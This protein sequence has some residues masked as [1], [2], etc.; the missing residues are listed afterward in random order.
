LDN[1]TTRVALAGK[2]NLNVCVVSLAN[3]NMTDSVLTQ[4]FRDAPESCI[5]LIEDIDA[6]FP[7]RED[8]HNLVRSI[9]CHSLSLITNQNPVRHPQQGAPPELMMMMRANNRPTSSVTFSGILNAIDGIASQ[10]GFVLFNDS[11]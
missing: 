2:L 8:H 10:E 3:I 6:A 11:R 1:L 7:T 4:A 9:F 5:L